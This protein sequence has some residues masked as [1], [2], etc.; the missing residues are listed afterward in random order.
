MMQ[1]S[2]RKGWFFKHE[3]LF[4]YKICQKY[5]IKMK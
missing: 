5:K 4:P 2:A 1:I 3:C